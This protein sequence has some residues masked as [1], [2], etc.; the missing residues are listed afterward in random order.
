[1]ARSKVSPW[2][3]VGMG[4]MACLLFLDLATAGIAPWWV[5]LLFLVL[6]VALFLVG[7]RWFLPHPTWVPLLPILGFLVW[8]PIIAIGS[9]QLGWG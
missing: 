1:V 3:F 7:T 5:T 6:W 8:L 2:G 9:R 4:A